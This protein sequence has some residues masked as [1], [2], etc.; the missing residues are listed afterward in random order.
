[1]KLFKGNLIIS[2]QLSGGI[3]DQYTITD[4][5]KKKVYKR[6]K[7]LSAEIEYLYSTWSN[8]DYV[9]KRIK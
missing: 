3:Q 4:T 9:I 8:Y 7:E 6:L 5:T 2:H 1:M